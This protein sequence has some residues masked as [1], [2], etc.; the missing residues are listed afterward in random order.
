MPGTV[1]PPEKRSPRP[2]KLLVRKGDAPHLVTPAHHGADAL[3]HGE[4]HARVRDA[5]NGNAVDG[6]QGRQP[7][8]D[9]AECAERLVACDD[10]LDHIPHRTTGDVF[11]P[12]CLLYGAAA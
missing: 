4:A 6:Q 12:A 1:S 9:V 11:T 5:R 8:T 7:R 10:R 3:P 2:Q